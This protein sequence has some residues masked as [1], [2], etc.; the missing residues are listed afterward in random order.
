MLPVMGMIVGGS[1]GGLVKYP[2]HKVRYSLLGSD[3]H[4]LLNTL[5]NRDSGY[6]LIASVPASDNSLLSVVP[7][8]HDCST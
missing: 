4:S 2:H 6:V 7:G 8:C 3:D 5:P 1:A